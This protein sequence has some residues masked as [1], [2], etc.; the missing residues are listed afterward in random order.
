MPAVPHLQML[1]AA[2]YALQL[3]H[4][5]VQGIHQRYRLFSGRGVGQASITRCR[6]TFTNLVDLSQLGNRSS[7]FFSNSFGSLFRSCR[8]L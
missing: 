8:N 2:E 5:Y 7:S 4:N 1:L 6:E 3:L